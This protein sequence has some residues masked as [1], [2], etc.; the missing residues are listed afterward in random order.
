VS[1]ALVELNRLTSAARVPTRSGRSWL[2]APLVAAAGVAAVR[3]LGFRGVDVPAQTY[4]A[5]VFRAHGWVL[6]DNGWYGGHYQVSYSV[7]FP[8]LGASIGLYG[9]ALL[10]A[11]TA[12][13]AFDRLVVIASGR[14]N[15]VAVILFAAGTIV[16]VAIGQLPFLAGEAVG[17]AALLAAHRNRRVVAVVLAASCALFSEVAGLFLVLAIITWA[18]TSPRDQRRRLF[19]LASVAVLPIVVQSL[20]LPRLGPFPFWG[21]DLAVVVGVCTL[22]VV[23]LPKPYRA[24][25]VGLALYGMAAVAVFVIP[26]PLGGNVGRLATYFA[27]ALFAFMATIP[28]RRV[29]ALL[30][31]PLL[32]WQYWPAVSSVQTDA[33]ADATYYAPV[34]D[35]LTRQPTI[36]RLEIPFTR[37]HWEAAYVAPR[38]PLARGWLRQ[39]DTLDNPIFYG[40]TSLNATTYHQWLE[41]SGVTWVALPDVALDYS[42]TD[43]AHLLTEGQPY[44]DLVWHNAH[45]RLWKVVGSPGLVSGPAHVIALEPDRVALDATGVGTALVRVRYT[46]MWN[47]TRGQACVVGESRNWTEV[48]LQH[49]GRVELTISPFA[50]SGCDPP[51]SSKRPDH[52]TARPAL[53]QAA[54]RPLKAA[55]TTG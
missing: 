51:A 14:R 43:E 34:V 44:L 47:V 23:A 50:S 9:A 5:E 21:P 46:P 36:G 26:N 45:W 12:A 19:A 52:S 39:L 18:L 2:W 20:A 40:P 49:P 4:I 17:L 54:P 41:K 35:Y 33:S 16:A 6:W 1:V 48:V 28:R 32:V 42:A 55:R 15:T 29:L 27:P 31:V 38:V 53:G 30:V 8:P 10:A 13:W 22:G 37:A 11:A 25:R 24:L 7:L 3:L